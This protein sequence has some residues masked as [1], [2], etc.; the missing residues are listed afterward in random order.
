MRVYHLPGSHPRAKLPPTG[1]P[2]QLLLS[3]SEPRELKSD[4]RKRPFQVTV[5]SCVCLVGMAHCESS[6]LEPSA[7]T[8]RYGHSGELEFENRSSW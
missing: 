5:N 3:I 8:G 7:I 4:R 1:P 6:V 2:S